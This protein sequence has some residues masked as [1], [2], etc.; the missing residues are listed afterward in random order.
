MAIHGSTTFFRLA[1]FGAIVV[2]GA[3]YP[4]TSSAAS[5][6]VL[7]CNNSG[8]GSLRSAVFSAPEGAVVDLRALSCSRILLTS[9]AI[10]VAQDDLQLLGRSR[11]ALT[12]DGNAMDRVLTH[13]GSGSLRITRLSIA[14]GVDVENFAAGGCIWS[15]AK[16]VLE[17]SSIH[18]CQATGVRN[19][20]DECE[21]GCSLGASGGAIAANEVR[22]AHTRVSDS[23]A[24]AFDSQGGGIFARSRVTMW[25][26]RVTGNVAMTGTGVFAGSEFVA[27]DSL[28]DHNGL[29]D[30][31][32]TFAD[33]GA[34][35]VFDGQAV[36]VRSAV[37][38]N[39]AVSCAGVCVEGR[40]AIVN[41]T[42]ARNHGRLILR[43][44][45]SGYL[46][47]TTVAVNSAGSGIVTNPAFC[48]GAITTPRLTLE[49]SIAALNRCGSN[50]AIDI[51]AGAITGSHNLVQSSRSALPADTLR[52][53]PKLQTLRDNGGPTPTMALIEGSPAIDHGRNALDL[54]TDQ[55][56][57]GFRRV[58]GSSADIGAFEFQQP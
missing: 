16:L 50:Y 48:F 23:R 14:N 45:E 42:I 15:R 46:A 25:N 41:S 8:P 19:P 31:G 22:L 4:S 24:D 5:I 39:A 29:E 30:S 54:R 49:S 57:H 7:N 27:H 34:V 21:L 3:A 40:G 58:S 18:H 56:G 9:G 2:A 37:V 12:I 13:T 32:E 35:Y 47:N 17:S 52:V 20:D 11:H 53:N 26:S 36:L 1:V 51:V 44:N 28:I 55:R 10:T 33:Q 43:F 38:D 6:A